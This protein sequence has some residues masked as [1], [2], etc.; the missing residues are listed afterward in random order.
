MVILQLKAST[1]SKMVHK[2]V[3][4]IIRPIFLYFL[5]LKNLKIDFWIPGK[6]LSEILVRTIFGCLVTLKLTSEVT[7]VGR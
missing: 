6:I 2:A 7:E 1:S 5:D 3:N 4:V